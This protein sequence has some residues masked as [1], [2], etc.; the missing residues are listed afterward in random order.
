MCIDGDFLNFSFNGYVLLPFNNIFG[1]LD[2]GVFGYVRQVSVI[3]YYTP[4]LCCDV[5]RDTFSS[6][7]TCPVRYWSSFHGSDSG[8]IV[9]RRRT[10]SPSVSHYYRL[11]SF[12][13]HISIVLT[14]T[15]TQSLSI[16]FSIVIS[17]FFSHILISGG[18]YDS[19]SHCLNRS[20]R[21]HSI[22]Y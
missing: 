11:S 1:L 7:S 18:F 8:S 21:P 20:H 17:L 10:G 22:L 3:R 16:V 9:K 12:V 19:D 15:I 6:T 2:S 5:T 13:L 4:S 14:H